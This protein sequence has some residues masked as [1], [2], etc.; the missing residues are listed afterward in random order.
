MNTAPKQPDIL[1]RLRSGEP[2]RLNDPEYAEIIRIVNR[3]I[4]LS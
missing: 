1:Q 2:I 3:T 4:R